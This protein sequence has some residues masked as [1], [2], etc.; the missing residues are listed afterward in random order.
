MRTKNLS[1]KEKLT[2]KLTKLVGTPAFLIFQTL[3]LVSISALSVS[4]FAPQV[5]IIN[6]ILVV[7]TVAIL[8]SILSQMNLIILSKRLKFLEETLR[9]LH[10]DEGKDHTAL[11]HLIHQIKSVQN[12]LEVVKKSSIFRHNGHAFRSSRK[13]SAER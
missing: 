3:I 2:L 6:M 9:E 10:E 4:G 13:I 5:L 1:P 11:V 8:L 7:A 12:D